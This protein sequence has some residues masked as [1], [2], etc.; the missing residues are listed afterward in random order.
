[1]SL[2]MVDNSGFG[3]RRS[4]IPEHR[5]RLVDLFQPADFL[6]RKLDLHGRRGVFQVARLGGPDDRGGDDR[7]GQHPGQGNLRIRHAVLFGH[8]ADPVGDRKIVVARVEG[9]GETV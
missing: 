3:E 2:P 4:G 1:M 9:F 7:F 5:V 8:L 6:L